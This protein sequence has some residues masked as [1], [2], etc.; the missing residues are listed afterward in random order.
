MYLALFYEVTDDYLDRRGAF[1]QDHLDLARA[2]HERGELALAG[3]FSDPADSA[4]LVWTTEDRGVV[5]Q[6]AARDPYVTNGLVKAWRIRE[7]N[8]V[9]GESR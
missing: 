1:R 8:V 9:V 6:F 5:E 7:W 3:A 4:L 2:A